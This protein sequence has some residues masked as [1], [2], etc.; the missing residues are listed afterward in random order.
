[1][2]DPFSP[3]LGV[4]LWT[5]VV[6]IVLFILLWRYAFPTILAMTEEREARITKQLQDAE[7]MQKDAAVL[8]EEQRQLLA[9]A[10][11][12]A[13][14]IVGEART[15][16]ERERAVAVEKTRQEQDELLERARREIAGER[17]RAV[18]DIRREAVDIAISAA[19]KVVGARLDAATDRK[20]VED[21]IGSMASG[22]RA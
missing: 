2:G 7:R 6:L 12:E 10:R 16:A 3:T 20:I 17:E 4:A 18:A 11:G 13:K 21:Y 19:G 15:A 9:S 8:L 1:M 14:A 22:A 5:F